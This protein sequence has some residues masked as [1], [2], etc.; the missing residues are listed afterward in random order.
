MERL[1]LKTDHKQ[2]SLRKGVQIDFRWGWEA[3]FTVRNAS[4]RANAL[5]LQD[6]LGNDQVRLGVSATFI[7]DAASTKYHIMRSQSGVTR[8]EQWHSSANI[9]AFRSNN[10]SFMTGNFKIGAS[11][12]AQATLDVEGDLIYK[13]PIV[14][15]DNSLGAI[16]VTMTE[17]NY[18][19]NTTV[20]IDSSTASNTV[21][22][23]LPALTEGL[24]YTFIAKTN[25]NAT[26]VTVTFSAPSAV[27][28][29]LVACGDGNKTIAGAGASSIT[30]M[31]FGAG[32]LKEH[33]KIEF[34]CDGTN[35]IVSGFSLGAVADITTS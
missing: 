22:Y 21:K 28:G 5:M 32:T 17:A 23:T 3:H 16:N 18:P 34:I 33:T 29:G 26:G 14:S 12:T 20:T 6:N 19:S 24:K 7:H 30:N 1:N 11:S 2:I 25:A 4:N 27:L 8:F 31:I 15:E 10:T 13:N 9:M 35:W